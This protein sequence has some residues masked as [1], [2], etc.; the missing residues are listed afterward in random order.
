MSRALEALTERVAAEMAVPAS[1]SPAMAAA[2]ALARDI[3]ASH[4]GS[5]RAVLFYGSCRRSG[6]TSGLLDLYVV[7]D[8]HRAFHGAG[9][10]A[11]LNALLPPNV[12]QHRAEVAGL[13]EVR[14]KVAVLSRRQFERRLSAASLDTTIWARFC[15]PAT[16]VHARDAEAAAWA[17]VAG[18]RAFMAAALWAARLGPRRGAPAAFWRALF[19]H[20]YG[21]ELRAERQGRGGSIH[22]AAPDWF[23]GNLPLAFAALGLDG[24]PDAEGQLAPGPPPSWRWPAGWALRRWLG[25]PLNI[26]RLV[27][28]AFTFEGGADYLVWKIER[29]SGERLALT[30]WQRRHPIAAAPRLLWRLWRRGAVR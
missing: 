15:Q 7:H 14:A 4:G 29:H 2:M 26:A 24:V 28:A 19:A 11:L 16:L 30:D 10:P 21:A 1:P 18:A 20:T 13:G 23:D 12:M 6:E 22:D 27:K 3:A 9:I 17:H 25:K 5:V 8:G